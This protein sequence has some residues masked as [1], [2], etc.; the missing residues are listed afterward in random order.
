MK[1]VPD[2]DGLRA[3]AQQLLKDNPNS[4]E[5]MWLI[6]QADYLKQKLASSPAELPSHY[7]GPEVSQAIAKLGYPASNT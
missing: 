5:A 7:K 4:G 1:S 2:P 3:R 6:D